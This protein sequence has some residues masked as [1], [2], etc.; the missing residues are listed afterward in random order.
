VGTGIKSTVYIKRELVRQFRGKVP[1]IIRILGF[2]TDVPQK[3]QLKLEDRNVYLEEDTEGFHITL[4][5]PD[6]FVRENDL[7]KSWA[8]PEK[9]I[10]YQDIS[11]GTGAERPSGRLALF[12]NAP[13]VYGEIEEAWRNITGKRAKIAT[14]NMGIELSSDKTVDIYIVCSVAGGTGS[15]MFLDIGYICRHIAGSLR[16]RVFGF[17]LLPRVFGEKGGNY[18]CSGNGYAAL[19]ELDYWVNED[20]PVEVSYPG[21]NERIFWGGQKN[22]PFDY[23]CLVDDESEEEESERIT[24][25]ADAVNFMA[26]GVFLHMMIES[27]TGST[28]SFYPNL[29]RLLLQQQPWLGKGNKPR[30][31]GLGIRSLEMPF[32]RTIDF[33]VDQTILELIQ[34]LHFGDPERTIAGETL[35]TYVS[36]RLRIEGLAGNAFGVEPLAQAPEPEIKQPWRGSENASRIIDWKT[37][38]V[39][40]FREECKNNADLE[41][42]AFTSAVVKVQ[43]SIAEQVEHMLDSD[44]GIEQTIKFLKELQEHL[45]NRNLS[46]VARITDLNVQKAEMKNRDSAVEDLINEAFQ[47]HHRK[48]AVQKAIEEAKR[49]IRDDWS[50]FTVELY[51]SNVHQELL[52][53]AKRY[54]ELHLKQLEKLRLLLVELEGRLQAQ[55]EEKRAPV[56]GDIFTAELSED[57]LDP[58][59]NQVKAGIGTDFL[60]QATR[61][62]IEAGAI[63]TSG[64]GFSA[65]TAL[66]ILSSDDFISW[67]RPIIKNEFILRK[68][69][70]IED[71]FEELAKSETGR[72]KTA[73]ELLSFIKDT[74]AYWPVTV[75]TEEQRK[76]EDLYV[77]ALPDRPGGSDEST[78]R[79]VVEE[80]YPEKVHFAVSWEKNRIRLLRLRIAAPLH[81]F[82][83]QKRYKLRYLEIEGKDIEGRNYTHHI[84][85]DWI[86]PN[87]ILPD[88]FPEAHGLDE[89]GT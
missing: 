25:V 81:H 15:G 38:Q 37:T 78:F 11:R 5:Q 43:S 30:Y 16:H 60:I 6:V 53:R 86:G 66:N 69:D 1:P 27:G 84:H 33:A 88:I 49:L 12:A 67:L 59:I 79:R 89:T 80:K 44:Q 3:Q 9:M 64:E 55:T 4:D 22:K 39:A 41:S 87:S 34:K 28:G 42:E 19:K 36:E 50:E 47:Q 54:V 20:K 40:D 31:M 10:S 58:S 18:Y 24:S 77:A 51:C 63:R 71:V 2:D 57:F 13:T 83:P 61:E 52:L 35:D 21:V 72:E 23:I 74:T 68:A 73:D 76:V 14:E 17:F 85:K 82:R 26:S 75:P 32:D 46:L 56:W 7:V 48:Q 62:K 70:T 8:P 65:L 29:D 45:S